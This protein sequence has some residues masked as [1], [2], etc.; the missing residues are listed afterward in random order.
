V[1]ALV[2]DVC[3]LVRGPDPFQAAAAAA[4]ATAGAGAEAGAGAVKMVC[5]RDP[6]DFRVHPVT[7]KVSET[8]DR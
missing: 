3:W 1:P 2:H 8:D 5:H 4:G 7:V 6:V